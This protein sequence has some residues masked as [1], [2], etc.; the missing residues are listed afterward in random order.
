MSEEQDT[1]E[2]WRVLAEEAFSISRHLTDLTA[3]HVMLRIAE[4]YHGLADR[5]KLRR[6]RDDETKKN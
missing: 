1:E 6:E 4:A 2:R 5:A 3:K